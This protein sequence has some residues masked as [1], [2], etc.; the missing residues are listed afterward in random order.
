MSGTFLNQRELFFHQLSSYLLGGDDCIDIPKDYHA[1]VNLIKHGIL[2]EDR[3]GIV[4][5]VFEFMVD[6][7]MVNFRVS[8]DND[9]LTKVLEEWKKNINS[10]MIQ[11]IPSGMRAL[12]GQYYRERWTSSMSALNITWK[13]DPKSGLIL[14][15]KMWFSDASKVY[16]EGNGRI[17]GSYEYW[18]GK[19]KN[20]SSRKLPLPDT[21]LLIR[22]SNSSWYDKYP[23]PYL[24]KR[25]TAY[26]WKFKKMLVEKQFDVL[27]SIMLYMLMAK[28]GSENLFLDGQDVDDSDLESLLKKIQELSSDSKSKTGAKGLIGAF[29]FDTSFEHFMPDLTKV[30]NED[31]VAPT[32]RNLLASLGLV[33]II[34]G[35]S[36]S[37]KDAIL[38][39]KPLVE[40]IK[41]GV[42]DFQDIMMDVLKIIRE[43]NIEKHPKMFTNTE[44]RI[45]A[46]TIKAFV[47]DGMRVMIRSWYDRGVVSKNQAIDAT[48]DL[49]F[50]VQVEDRVSEANTGLDVLMEPP[51][52]IYNPNEEGAP[53]SN[54]DT[55]EDKTSQPGFSAATEIGDVNCD[56]CGQAINCGANDK[57]VKCPNCKVMLNRIGQPVQAEKKADGTLTEEASALWKETF[58]KV[59]DDNKELPKSQRKGKATRIAWTAVRKE[60]R[61]VA[62]KWIKK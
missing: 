62:G 57:F 24:V 26:H 55:P 35:I 13:Q 48:T 15:D 54:T 8:T 9:N 59:F 31:I 36:T 22:K 41:S 56:R 19:P 61:L 58:N 4:A 23:S 40:E 28:K 43:K 14:P 6:T 51:K 2:D 45:T 52:I 16:V 33:E 20:K 5:T 37:R 32:D 1:R 53:E 21:T 25:G 3:S 17:L 12:A 60:Y 29:P 49:D 42:S 10:D 44:M 7:A 34:E 27:K 30:F 39:P 46:S 47:T 18:I 11:E 38:N 50:E